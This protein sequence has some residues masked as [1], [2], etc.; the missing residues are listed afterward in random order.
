MPWMA[1]LISAARPL[2]LIVRGMLGPVR[3]NRLLLSLGRCDRNAYY[4]ALTE[5][6]LKRWLQPDSVCIDVGCHTGAIL[7]IMLSYAAKGRFYAFEPLPDLFR[8]L[9]ESFRNDRVVLSE[10]AL[11]DHA[12]LEPFNHV[13]TNPGYS[14]FVMR[15]YD[16][17]REQDETIQVRTARL[18]DLIDAKD[19]V[20][21][22]KIDVEGA[23]LL[24]LKGA[25]RTLRSC[26]PMILFEYGLGAADCYGTRPQDMF[27]YLCDGLGFRISLLDRWL[28]G[29]PPLS[30]R[31]FE[32]QFTR[33]LNWYFV[34]YP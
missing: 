16:R 11:S 4:D 31:A 22:I 20:D 26:R 21:F 28:L 25:E 8:G 9:V 15:R 12:G 18:D 7:R 19:R 27:G 30:R 33:H 32:A 23:E 10:L 17:P 5:E 13:I 6:I 29:W 34:A 2:K 24:V 14:G 3:W 1:L